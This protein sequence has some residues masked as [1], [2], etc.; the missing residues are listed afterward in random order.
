MCRWSPALLSQWDS[1]TTG[2]AQQHQHQ[3]FAHEK[4]EQ[5]VNCCLC[6]RGRWFTAFSRRGATLVER[7]SPVPAVGHEEQHLAD[8]AE[9]VFQ[10]GEGQERQLG[11]AF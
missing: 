1:A 5:Q 6:V 11:A 3:F 8:A 9:T 7:A 10:R 2:K 4:E